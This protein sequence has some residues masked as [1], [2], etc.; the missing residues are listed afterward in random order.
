M[1]TASTQTEWV[2]SDAMRGEVRGGRFVAGFSGEQYRDLKQGP[3][4]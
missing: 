2:L 3:T 1:T 4:S